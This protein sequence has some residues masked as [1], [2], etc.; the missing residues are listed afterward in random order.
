[1]S[2]I[3]PGVRYICEVY[4][5]TLKAILQLYLDPGINVCNDIENSWFCEEW[6]TRELSVYQD[7]LVF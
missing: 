1:M 5:P 2:L 3:T 7:A 6:E 4:E